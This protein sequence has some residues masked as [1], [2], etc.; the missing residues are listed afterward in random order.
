MPTL[1]T[2]DPAA[3]GDLPHTVEVD[4]DSRMTRLYLWTYVANKHRMNTC[5][6]FWAFV[7]MPLVLPVSAAIHALAAVVIWTDSRL[8]EKP[9]PYVPPIEYTGPSK[10]ER[11]LESVSGFMAKVW[12]RLQPLLKWGGIA[13]GGL[14][15]AFIVGGLVY[16]VLQDPMEVLTMLLIALGIVAA[17]AVAVG[18]LVLLIHVLDKSKKVHG[19]FSLMGKLG[20]NVHHHTCANVRVKESK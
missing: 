13:I 11:A 20:R 19:F 8:P 9:K 4:A 12:F 17:A 14:I 2:D 18:L 6:L 1:V 16:F 10:G 3:R 15:A 7:F 5:K